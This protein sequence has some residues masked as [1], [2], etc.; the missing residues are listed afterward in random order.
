MECP[1]SLS[2]CIANNVFICDS[3][4]MGTSAIK[5]LM[6]GPYTTTPYHCTTVRMQMVQTQINFKGSNHVA[7][8]GWDSNSDT[9]T[10]ESVHHGW[11]LLAAPRKAQSSW[12]FS[13][14]GAGL[15]NVGP[16]TS[17]QA[18]AFSRNHKPGRHHKSR[19]QWWSLHQKQSFI[20]E[21]SLG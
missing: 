5:T 12:V 17:K 3:F 4:G 14:P 20:F 16:L 15:C 10:S 9:G 19:R 2:I 13:L 11:V 21:V 6:S 1:G 8:V 18:E 7:N